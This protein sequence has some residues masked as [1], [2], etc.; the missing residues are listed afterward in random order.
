MNQNLLRNGGA[1]FPKTPIQLRFPR[2]SIR[3][4]EGSATTFLDVAETNAEPLR[5]ILDFF[6][7]FFGISRDF[8]TDSVE[9][10]D[11]LSTETFSQ[12]S[13]TLDYS[14]PTRR[15]NSCNDFRPYI[16]PF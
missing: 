10:R 4:T 8:L 9:I 5:P 15:G 6:L 3:P 2:A 12:T 11:L 13:I 7:L 14:S 16:G 1:R